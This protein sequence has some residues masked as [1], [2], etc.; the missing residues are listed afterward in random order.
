MT[1]IVISLIKTISDNLFVTAFILLVIAIF[2]FVLH[3][4]FKASFHLTEKIKNKVFKKKE[5]LEMNTKEESE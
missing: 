4:H 5:T 1:N 2:S 3:Y